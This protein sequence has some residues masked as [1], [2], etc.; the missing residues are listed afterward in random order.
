[1]KV[2]RLQDGARVWRC[3]S[4]G[5]VGVVV[6]GIGLHAHGAHAQ[7]IQQLFPSDIPGYSTD[8]TGSVVTRQMMGQQTD[9]IGLGSWLLRPSASENV[10]YNSNTLGI[11]GSGSPVV[12]T[13]ANVSVNSRWRRHALGA[14]VGM[15]D[16]RYPTQSI[17]SYT[18]WHGNIGG[19][20]NLGHDTLSMAYSHYQYH[21]SATNLGVYGVVYPVPYQVN[22]GRL[23]YTKM[24]GRFSLI[25]AFDYQDFSFG[26]A[27]GPISIDYGTISHKTETG[28][29]TSRYEFSRGNAA[30]IVF[31]GST[32]QYDSAPEASVNNY[33]DGA[34]FGG[35]DF[36]SG[37]V[38]QYR[39]LVGGETRS[40]SSGRSPSVTTPTFEVNVSWMPRRIDTVTLTA[41]RHLS[42]PETPFARNQVVTDVRMQWDHEL[43]HNVFLRAYAEYGESA[44]QSSMTVTTGSA[45]SS[46]EGSRLQKQIHFGGSVFWNIDRHVRASLTY[47]YVNNATSGGNV[48]YLNIPGRL[49]TF[50]SNTILLGFS[51]SG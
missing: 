51:F 17:A 10:G 7:L 24:F 6:L 25:P 22:D 36:R 26:T 30:V 11:P 43:R 9:G 29:L 16:H 37:Q 32:A 40:F 49:S 5:P 41:A 4:R 23:T 50:T 21:L 44:S 28:S 15:D 46:L 13:S 14:S 48:N 27:P 42:D 47:N 2:G 38:W 31:R 1:M 12:Q 39:L 19:T 18:N 33:A 20:L 8:M 34:G 3:L 35:V 45:T